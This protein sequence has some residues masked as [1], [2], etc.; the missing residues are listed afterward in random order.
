MIHRRALLIGAS[1]IAFLTTAP[2]F[3]RS[4]NDPWAKAREIVRN[5]KRP[6][7]GKRRVTLNPPPGTDIRPA[8]ANA[9]KQLGPAGGTVIL[10]K[11]E[12]TS[13]GPIHFTSRIALHV[14]KG[15]H[16]KFSREPAHYL[17][18][19]F[20]RWEGT[21]C[22]NYS[23]LIYANGV[24]DIAITGGGIIDG[25]GF[26]G[27]FKWRP[28]QRESQQLLRKMG[29]A[30]V[31]VGE[32]RFGPGHFLR[33]GFVQFISC[34][35][36]L[37]DGPHF[38][39]S[40]FWMIHPVY[41]DHVTVRNVNLKSD[42]LNSDGIDPDSSTN[43]LIERCIFDVGDDG[44]AIKAGRDQDGWRVAKPSSRIVVR[45]CDYRGT[46]GGG[47]SIGSEM[48]GGVQDIFV[49]RYRMG[50]VS[51]G[52]YFKSNLDRGGAIR[53]VYIRDIRIEKAQAV[54]IFT[55]DYHGYR[56]GQSPPV[57]Q[58]I[59]INTVECDEAIVGLSL[60]GTQGAPLQRIAVSNFTIGKVKTPMRVKHVR[61]LHF[62]AVSANGLPLNAVME[63]APDTFSDKIKL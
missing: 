17:P 42:H 58:D 11:G 26:E 40:P 22:W 20:T 7:I 49:E 29:A 21:E 31:P 30:E 25:Q 62:D 44:V 47:F 45:D 51:H 34:Q 63:T 35:R 38:I 46:A 39:D 13:H 8:I 37:I 36:I 52:L 2:A 32:R 28:Q 9:M 4:T 57:F 53:D 18:M 3:A 41:C 33:P 24:T 60:V 5:I 27:F 54:L 55:T 48:S 43:V 23:P 50:N 16:L 15:T 19:V 59:S 61:D 10:P 1:A 56:G 6:N 12:W 14:P